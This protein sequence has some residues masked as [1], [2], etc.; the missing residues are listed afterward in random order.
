VETCLF[1]LSTRLDRSAGPIAGDDVS[2]YTLSP[3]SPS[4]VHNNIISHRR[5]HH[6]RRSRSQMH[7]C[8][9]R[10]I[11]A[12]VYISRVWAATEPWGVNDSRPSR[13]HREPL[14]ADNMPKLANLPFAREDH[15]RRL[16]WCSAAGRR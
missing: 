10:M 2:T 15:R 11:A 3:L 12:A 7:Y 16:L 13:K 8:R 14:T 4:D 1:L 5:R 9:S 6:R